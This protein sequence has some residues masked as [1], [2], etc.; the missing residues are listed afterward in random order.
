MVRRAAEGSWQARSS[1]AARQGPE[2]HGLLLGSEQ[3]WKVFYTSLKISRAQMGI[4]W[5][6]INLKP[7]PNLRQPSTS[8]CKQK[9]ESS[10]AVKKDPELHT[11]LRA[12]RM[13]LWNAAGG[14]WP[15]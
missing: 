10:G 15:G 14:G 12:L 3:E 11:D 1:T 8:S 6:S 13:N 7:T 2:M 9:P 5:A 4:K